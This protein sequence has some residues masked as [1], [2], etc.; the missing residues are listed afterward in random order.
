M[1]VRSSR[2]QGAPRVATHD[3]SPIVWA[4]DAPEEIAEWCWDAGFSVY[5][6]EDARGRSVL[7]IVDPLGRRIELRRR[8]RCL[9][10]FRCVGQVGVRSPRRGHLR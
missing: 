7:S 1:S 6:R 8:A 9:A 4:V 10:R 3:D 5:V 2:A